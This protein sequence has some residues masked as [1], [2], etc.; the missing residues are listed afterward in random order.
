MAVPLDDSIIQRRSCEN[1]G[2]PNVIVIQL[3]ELSKELLSVRIKREQL[4]YATDGKAEVADA[5]LAIHAGRIERNAIKCHG[6]ALNTIVLQTC[7]TPVL[8]SRPSS[9]RRATANAVSNTSRVRAGSRI[10]STHKR[11][12]A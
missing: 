5:R 7:N 6:S 3:R 9:C 1:Q 2:L 8:N 4:Q 12:A 11:A 10:A